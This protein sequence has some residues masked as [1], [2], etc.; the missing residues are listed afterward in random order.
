[1]YREKIKETHMTAH[2]KH[3]LSPEGRARIVEAQKRRWAKVNGTVQNVPNVPN[4]EAK[5]EQK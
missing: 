4:V 3:V 1:M 5:E 2:K